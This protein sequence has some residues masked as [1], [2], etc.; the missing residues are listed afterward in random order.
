MIAR[1]S[2]AD[3]GWLPVDRRARHRQQ[4]ASLRYRQRR[5]L[6]L[7]HRAP[8]RSA[9]LP[10]FRAK[11]SFSTFN[12]PIC[13]YRTSTVPRWLHPWPRHAVKNTGRAVQQLL[14]PIVDLVRMNPELA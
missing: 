8:F 5:V 13:R 6:S 4:P 2:R 11:K 7:D 14:F 9:H 10:S 3:L 1:S 12:W